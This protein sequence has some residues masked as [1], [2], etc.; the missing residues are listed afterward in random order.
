VSRTVLRESQ[1]EIPGSTYQTNVHFHDINLLFDA[2]RKVVTLTA[3]LSERHGMSDWRQHAY[4]VRHLKRLMRAAQN[5]KRS[6]AKSEEQQAK[7]QSVN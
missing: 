6:R 2:M 3:E 1:G 5:K 7:T 4:N